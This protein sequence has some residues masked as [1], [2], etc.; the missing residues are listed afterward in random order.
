MTIA[1]REGFA[2]VAVPLIGSGTGSQSPTRVQGLMTDELA[3]IEFQGE[4][5]L[6]VYGG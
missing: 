5:R 3:R 4:V 2:S 1:S 6:V